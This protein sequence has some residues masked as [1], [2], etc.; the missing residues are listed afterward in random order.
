MDASTGCKSIEGDAIGALEAF[1][2]RGAGRGNNSRGLRIE[3][4]AGAFAAV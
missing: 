3:G 2:A 4:L 1:T